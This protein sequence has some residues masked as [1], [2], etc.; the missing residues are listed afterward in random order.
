M[1]KKL[2]NKI[3]DFEELQEITTG[4]RSKE[5]KKF[6]EAAIRYGIVEGEKNE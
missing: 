2:K 1:Q 3:N 5:H 6:Y 4:D